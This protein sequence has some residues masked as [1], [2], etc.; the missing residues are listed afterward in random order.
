MIMNRRQRNL[1]GEGRHFIVEINSD[2]YRL[3]RLSEF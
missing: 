3:A 1:I 2:D